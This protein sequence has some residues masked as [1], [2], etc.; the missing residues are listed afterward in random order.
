MTD[1][2]RV[3]AVGVVRVSV[4]VIIPEMPEP[5]LLDFRQAI[6]EIITQ[7]TGAQFELRMS[8]PL[9]YPRR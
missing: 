4:S 9:D 7:F 1:E 6:K 2:P 5:E 3:S 8:D